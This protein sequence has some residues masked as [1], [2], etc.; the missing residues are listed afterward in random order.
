MSAPV[1]VSSATAR[2]DA[3]QPNRSATAPVTKRPQK[4]P[5]LEPEI[6]SPAT[7]GNV[8]RRPFVADIGDRHSENRRQQQAL[9][10]AQPDELRHGCAQAHQQRR[11]DHGERRGGDQ[12]LSSEHVGERAGEWRGKRDR[13]GRCRDQ[14]ADVGGADAELARQLRQQRL[15]RIEI[16]ERGKTRRGN[17]ERAKVESHAALW[18]RQRGKASSA[19]E[20]GA[21][22]D[23]WR[24]AFLGR[25]RA[26]TL[27]PA[28]R[29]GPSFPLQLKDIRIDLLG[30][31]ARL[32]GA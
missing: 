1:S 24:M 7:R 17:G 23:A 13:R 14:R 19:P 31:T 5:T 30:G 32:M 18:A 26:C 20:C 27:T 25:H 6:N 21:D 4:P 12:A 9:H 8:G 2:N 16:N 11:H 29:H 15:R 28:I 10:E 3:R 22:T